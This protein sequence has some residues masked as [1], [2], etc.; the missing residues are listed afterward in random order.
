[1]ARDCSICDF[2]GEYSQKKVIFSCFFFY[3]TVQNARFCH[4]L[5]YC[6]F[7]TDTTSYNFVGFG[8]VE[9]CRVYQSATTVSCAGV[10]SVSFRSSSGSGSLIV[11]S[12]S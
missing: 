11:V 2:L 6:A 4:L 10:W 5:T 12:W 9:A 1:M 7:L 8:V 3:E